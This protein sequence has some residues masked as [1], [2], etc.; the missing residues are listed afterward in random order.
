M[1]DL[2]GR[3]AMV[4]GAAGHLGQAVTHALIAGHASTVLVDRDVSGLRRAFAGLAATG[5]HLLAEATDLTIPAEAEAAV[6]R[7]LAR[8]GQLDILIHL[9]GGFAPKLSVLETPL[10]AWQQLVSTNLFTTVVTCRAVIPAM[11]AS[12][13]GRIVTVAARAALASGPG[14]GPFAAAKA[15]VLRLTETLAEELW[16]TIN[17]NCVVPGTL[18]T[19]AARAERPEADHARWIAPE[20]VAQAILFLV[21]EEAR[22]ITGVAL[23]VLGNA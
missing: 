10:Q 11:Q 16:P 2:S 19:P 22:G 6:A 17:V 3:V 23:P 14:L 15:G 20:A 1:L 12:G 8:F 9:V 13:H 18:D 4:T 21:S 5:R 7:T